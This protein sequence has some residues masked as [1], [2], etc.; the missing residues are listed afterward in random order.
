[1]DEIFPGVFK[2]LPTKPLPSKCIT[3]FVRR[4]EGNLLFPC[5]S[6]SATIHARFDR[7]FNQ[8]GTRLLAEPGR[9]LVASSMSLVMPVRHRRPSGEV[10]L[11]DGLYG[12]LQ[13]LFIAPIRFPTS[14]AVVIPCRNEAR[15]IGPLLDALA[16][17][18]HPPA[19]RRPSLR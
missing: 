14:I 16:A 2:V 9:A 1:M 18:T 7:H 3:F 8:S 4:G 10:F 17:Q 5:F 15:T 19:G 6:G 11:G 12:A 13:E